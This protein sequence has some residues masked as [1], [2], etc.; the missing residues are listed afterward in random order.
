MGKS[1]EELK[2]EIKSLT[3]KMVASQQKLA[4]EGIPMFVVVEGWGSSGKGKL[5]H[6]VIRKC[7]PRFY[8]VAAI[9]RIP[10]EDR[11]KPFL[12][13]YF[14]EIPEN[15]KIVITDT[16][17]MNEVCLEKTR[18][19]I[20]EDEWNSR[21]DCINKFERSLSDNG[22]L[23]VKIFLDIDKKTQKER[24]DALKDDD[25]RNWRV[26]DG[27]KWQQK[28]YDKLNKVFTEYISRTDTEKAPWHVI[29]ATDD[30]KALK[31][32]L[33]IITDSVDEAIANKVKEPEIP[34]NPYPLVEMPLLADVPLKGK[35]L[36]EKEYKK[37]LKELQKKL[38]SLHDVLYL[39]KIPVI[40]A[41]EGWDAAGKG[42][43]IMRVSEALDPRGCEVH[44]IASPIPAEKQRHFLWR[45]YNR[46]PKSGH[47]AIFDRT[48][49]GRVMV[50]RLEGFCSE[51]DWKRAYN[52]M[53]EFEKDLSDW[54]AVVI[55]F[56]IQIDKDTQLERF[57]LRQ[58][59]PEKQW[60]ITDEDWR[61]REKWDLYEEAIDEMIAK[62]S[63]EFAPWYIIES[64]DKKYARIKALEIIVKRLEEAI[65]E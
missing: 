32:M 30:K 48:W 46:L 53:N 25:N 23:I 43:N 52:E 4:A 22:Y 61:N 44:P 26:N 47:V 27:D 54:G 20:S 57:T 39:R 19:D 28:H 55:K 8:R 6:G 7:D 21:I 18:E 29:D 34:E 38:R 1:K 58:N 12:W 16:G 3:E 62:T 49:Y 14:R 51:N 17:W 15:G 10:R 9:E 37:R 42:G 50:E 31:N 33:K 35:E 13:R 36:S 24:I 41:Y 63:T 56:W 11:R 40:I 64:V 60:K 2:A 65:G 59:T 5:I 45:F